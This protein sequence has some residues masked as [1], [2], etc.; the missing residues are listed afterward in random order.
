MSERILGGIMKWKFYDNTGAEVMDAVS[1]TDS[2]INASV[3]EDVVRAGDS[4][5]RLGSIFYD[6]NLAIS[7]TSQVFK[8]EYLA[9]KFGADITMS[10]DV[11]TTETVTVAVD[12]EITVTGTPVAFPNTTL[13]VGSYKAQGATGLGTKITFSG[14]TAPAVGVSAG[15]VVCVTY[16]HAD[17][18]AREFKIPSS[19]IPDV[20]YGVGVVNEF[21]SGTDTSVNT[22]SS[23]VGT[24]QCVVP[25][26][27]LDPNADL[28]L[29][30]SGHASIPL[31]GNALI[32]YDSTCSANGFYA[33]LTE[34][35]VGGDPFANCIA[36]GIKDGDVDLTV[37]DTETLQVY[38]FYSDGTAPSLLD[39]SLLSFTSATG[40]TATVGLH[41]GLV[42]AIGAGTSVISVVVDSK[43]SLTTNCVVTVTE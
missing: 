41:T 42:T 40:A 30:S 14:Q 7:L 34:T 17:A 25:Q 21:K 39:N 29:T 2:G 19:M 12:D 37:G 31:G 3:S 20:L 1:L 27:Q 8:M 32:N 9:T 36:I 11:Q 15:D 35:T 10:S 5:A 24:L 16:F 23:V 26:F 13:V 38:G 18:S 33:I 22:T 28:A 4:N 6:S 43:T